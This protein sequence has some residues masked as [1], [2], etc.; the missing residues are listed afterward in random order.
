MSFPLHTVAFADNFHLFPSI[1]IYF[2]QCPSILQTMS[3]YFPDNVYLFSWLY[4]QYPSSFLSRNRKNSFS[5]PRGS[6]SV[7]LPPASPHSGLCRQ[8]P[9]IFQTMSIYFSDNAHLFSRQC[10]SI[11]QTLP[12][13]FPGFADNVHLVSSQGTGTTRSPSPGGPS[14]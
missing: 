2:S 12:I 9:S 14:P 1:S 11:F 4:R 8:F 13:Y 10:P 7:S 5:Q 6:F 3:I